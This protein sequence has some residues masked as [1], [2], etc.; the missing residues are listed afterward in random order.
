MMGDTD[1]RKFEGAVSSAPRNR[2]GATATND[3][4]RTGQKRGPVE[5]GTPWERGKEEGILENGGKGAS[6]RGVTC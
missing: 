6:S 5:R 4:A 3:Q 1:T 2:G